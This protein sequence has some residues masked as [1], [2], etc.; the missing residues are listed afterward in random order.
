MPRK[1]VRKLLPSHQ[2]VRD[3]RY[4]GALGPA[5]HHPNLW[6]LN[7]RSVAGGVAI[8]ML[9]GMIPL[10]IQMVFATI[11]AVVLRANLPVALATTWYVNPFTIVPLY[12]L[13]Y[14]VGTL[15]T[16]QAPP[17]TAPPV[18]ALS[19]ANIRDWIP[20]LLAWIDEMGKPFAVGLSTLGAILSIGSYFAVRGIW[21]LYIVMAWRR[22][23][24]MRDS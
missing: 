20:L 24:R 4:V 17:S 14:K 19:I 3:H 11:F 23:S 18:V 9:C 16:E 7:R 8:G 15:I 2:A 12:Y 21:R 5:F 22:R 1:Y 6:H 10:P 13:A